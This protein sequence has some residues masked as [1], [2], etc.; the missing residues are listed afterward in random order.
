MSNTWRTYGG[1]R[2]TKAI[3]KFEMGTIIIDDII[4]RSKVTTNAENRVDDA[5]LLIR[6]GDL[7]VDSNSS[8]VGGNVEAN[9][10]IIVEKAG[11]FGEDVFID[12]RLYFVPNII[13]RTLDNSLNFGTDTATSTTITQATTSTYYLNY[14]TGNSQSG[15][16]GVGLDSP[17]TRFDV[18]GN[19]GSSPK[20]STPFNTM[21][22]VTN[23]SAGR[24]TLIEL[25]NDAYTSGIDAIALNKNSSLNFYKENVTSGTG[26]NANASVS[27]TSSTET[28]SLLNGNTSLTLNNV[29]K[30]VSINVS[31]NSMIDISSTTIQLNGGLSLAAGKSTTAV[32]D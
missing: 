17:L 28:F 10:N 30:T 29:N 31:G 13:E 1:M 19:I 8:N 15:N 27:Y 22:V 9:V 5:N 7:Q 3:S 24:T 32:F 26:T 20:N 2:K 16:I 25:S 11:L 6:G 14:I 12:N 21:R 4:K 23:N 18:F